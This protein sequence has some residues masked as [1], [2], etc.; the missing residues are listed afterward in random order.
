VS[1]F[2]RWLEKFSEDQSEIIEHF[3]NKGHS[4]YFDS[5]LDSSYWRNHCMFMKNIG[6][7][8]A[9]KDIKILDMGTHFGFTPHF[10]KSEGFINV[11]STN[12][13]NEAGDMLGDIQEMWGMLDLNPIDLHIQPNEKFKLD[14]KYDV[15]FATMSNIFWRS[16]KI[17][18]FSRGNITQNWSIIDENGEPTTFFVPYEM[19]ELD[20]F[21]KNIMEYL[22][23]GGIAVIQPYPYV[24][25]KLDGFKEEADFLKTFQNPYTSYEYPQSSVHTPTAELNNYFVVQKME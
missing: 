3:K 22:E 4:N 1:K 18:N 5:S 24:Y 16:N 10:L 15:I 2:E 12:S 8:Y 13:F 20:F 9:P 21:I 6:L 7:T 19:R 14:K 11:D 17:V 23:P 25:N